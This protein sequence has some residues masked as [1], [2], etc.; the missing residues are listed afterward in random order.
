MDLV[1]MESVE[2]IVSMVRFE[3]AAD[4]L[5][6]IPGAKQRII[7]TRVPVRIAYRSP[8]KP[9]SDRAAQLLQR[10]QLSALYRVAPSLL[11]LRA[12]HAASFQLREKTLAPVAQASRSGRDVVPSQ[13][14]VIHVSRGFEHGQRFVDITN[15]VT[16]ALQFLRK[17]RSRTWA[18]A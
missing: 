10:R 17:L 15:L 5:R 2:R 9:V 4:L 13:F 11:G 14:G 7:H 12:R 16:Q 3:L 18:A 1:F 6:V 8:L